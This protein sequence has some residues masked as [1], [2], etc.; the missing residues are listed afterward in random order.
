MTLGKPRSASN[1]DPA[2]VMT[3]LRRW[4]ARSSTAVALTWLDTEIERQQAGVDERKLII[5]LG[6]ASRKIGR[7]DLSLTEDDSLEARAVRTGWQPEL[8]GTDEA[9]RAAILLATYT[10]D[11]GVFAGRV[12]RLC[13]NAEVT[14]LLAYLKAF[15]IFPA[16]KQLHDRAREGVRSAVKPVFEAIACHNPYP[17]DYFDQAAWNQMVVK[18]VFVGTSIKSIVGITERANPDLHQMLRDLI[19][20]RH[21]AGRSVPADVRDYVV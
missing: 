1:P 4:V 19:S 3:L 21:A 8:W 7:V 13:A 20:E 14:E 11:G 5:A 12:E 17:L 2:A 15:A 6:M 9:A 16:A 10:G 18:A